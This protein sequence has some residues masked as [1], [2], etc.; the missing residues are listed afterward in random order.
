MAFRVDMPDPAATVPPPQISWFHSFRM[1]DGRQIDGVKS[2][3]LLSKEAQIVFRSS[4]QGRT[5]LDIG[6]WDGFFSFEAERRGAKSVLATDH[7][8]WSGPGWGSKRG[9]DH[10]GSVLNSKVESR[11]VDVVELDPDEFGRFDDVLMLG[12]LYH[13][14]D[15]YRCLEAAAAVCSDHLVLE[16]E[17]ALEHEPAPAMR[18]YASRELNDD[19]TN[20]WAPNT[21]ALRLML[22]DLGFTRI[23]VTDSPTVVRGSSLRSRIGAALR[24]AGVL[25]RPAMWGRGRVI[26]HAWR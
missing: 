10:V 25:K 17:T 15:P 7:F 22:Q 24:R 19:P 9:F 26:I 8:C 14:K 13:V 18:L 3:D 20:F 6:A 11:D 21:A 16:T 23:E 2:Y 4:V 5:V 1:P 12:V